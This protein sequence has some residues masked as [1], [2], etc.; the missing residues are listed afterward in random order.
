MKSIEQMLLGYDLDKIRLIE[1][2][3]DK[4]F[5]ALSN[6]W[7]NVVAK[8][9]KQKFLFLYMILQNALISYQLSWSWEDWRKEFADWLLIYLNNIRI[10]V[11]GFDNIFR[12][13]EFLSKCKKNS[14]LKLM[15]I[16]RLNTFTLFVNDID[17]I[18]K[19]Y[20]LYIDMLILRWIVTKI[21]RQKPDSKTIVFAVKMFWYWARIVFHKFIPFPS[22][23]NI[24]IDSRL[25]KICNIAIKKPLTQAIIKKFYDK[26][27]KKF[28]IPQLHL[29]SFLWI[30]YWKHINDNTFK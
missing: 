1:E 19:L 7:D 18:D 15:K 9:N 16:K 3:E 11:N 13:T 4:Q 27:S 8:T 5:V 22:E 12:W 14:R 29:D 21:M 6:C 28:N 24:P 23:I 17:N 20:N 25:T 26:L 2:I 30:K 10:S